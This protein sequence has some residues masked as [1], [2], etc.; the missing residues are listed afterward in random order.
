MVVAWLPNERVLFQGDLFFVP[1]NNAPFG[2]PQP[3][4][5][6]FAKKLKKLGLPVQRIASVHGATATIEQ[7]KEATAGVR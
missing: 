3:T 4:T 7:F 2:P 1:A 5:V 6:A